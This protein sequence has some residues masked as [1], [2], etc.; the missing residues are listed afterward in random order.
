RLGVRHDR[1]NG[2]PA[3]ARGEAVQGP[4]LRHRPPRRGRGPGPG[5]ALFAKNCGVCHTLFGEGG[6]VGPDLTNTSRADTP[7]LL[8]S[9]VDP[10]AVV[11]AQYVQYAVHTTDG[12]VRTGVIAEQDAASLTLVDAKAERTRVPRDRVESLRE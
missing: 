7:W 10:S 3:I 8:A 5:R 11:R 12:V 9:V 1:G 6:A 2:Q 4:P